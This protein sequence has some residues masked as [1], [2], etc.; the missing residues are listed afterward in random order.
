M[1]I[2]RNYILVD[3]DPWC[4]NI[5]AFNIK[6]ALGHVDIKAFS[7]AA[8][9]LV[10]INTEFS[11][12]PQPTILY[13]DINMPIMNGWDFLEYFEQFSDNIKNNISI[14]V[15]SSSVNQ[16]DIQRAKAN[17]NVKDFIS[18]TLLDDTIRLLSEKE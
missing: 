9:A 6:K 3:D 18:K 17:N 12:N 7:G 4:N 15:L 13:L 1:N 14:Y 8:E 5:C 11:K 16:S 10:F 2:I